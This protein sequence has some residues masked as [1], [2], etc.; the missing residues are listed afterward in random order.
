MTWPFHDLGLF[1]CDLIVQFSIG[2]LSNSSVPFSRQ[3]R[4]SLSSMSQQACEQRS[5]FALTSLKSSIVRQPLF[6]TP[7][8]HTVLFFFS[9]PR[10]FSSSQRSN[11]ER[12]R[13]K[14]LHTSTASS[15][16]HTASSDTPRQRHS[17]CSR[18]KH[19]IQAY[20]QTLNP[21][22][23]AWWLVENVL[24][25]NTPALLLHILI[26]RFCS[27]QPA[28]FFIA[29]ICHILVRTTILLPLALA[30]VLLVLLVAALI[31]VM[32]STRNNK[33]I[34]R[35]FLKAGWISC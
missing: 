19:P 6:D 12:A 27:W 8:L 5:L 29:L 18:H 1:Q 32:T 28:A 21:K 15:S 17:R 3:K 23:M 33:Q 9:F 31:M 7:H 20:T 11:Q 13:E 10:L 16:T 35:R 24:I 14:K 4:P 22:L 30:K 25:I 26:L 2:T 34:S